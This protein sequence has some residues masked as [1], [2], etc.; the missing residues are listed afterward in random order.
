MSNAVAKIQP[1]VAN[2]WLQQQ[3]AILVDIREPNEYAREHILKARHVP[4]SGFDKA[5]FTDEAEKS[6]IFCCKSGMRTTNNIERILATGFKK[7]YLLDGGIDAWKKAGL[8]VHLNKKAPIEI[9]RQVQITAG[10]LAL[11]GTLAG[12]YINPDF[13]IVPAFIGAGLTFAG[14]SGR[15]GLAHVLKL[16]PWNK[17]QIS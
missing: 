3:K 6:A 14:I 13:L 9:M 16:M 8:P 17:I 12:I 1:N 4:L 5:D 7:V 10:S 11:G 15:C 2:E